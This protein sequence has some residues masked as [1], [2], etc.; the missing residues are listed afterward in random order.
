MMSAIVKAKKSKAL[1]LPVPTLALKNRTLGEMSE[2]VL[3]SQRCNNDKV[4]N[5]G[6]K[7]LF[8]TLQKALGEIYK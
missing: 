7:F 5:A 2:V 3:Q 4:I 6:Y 1:L 8:P